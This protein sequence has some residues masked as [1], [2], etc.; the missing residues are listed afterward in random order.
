MKSKWL[1]SFIV[2]GVTYVILAIFIGEGLWR[3]NAFVYAFGG[4][5]AIIYYNM[6]FHSWY[7]QG[8]QLHNMNYP[9]GES[10]LMTDA[11]ASI[12][13]ILSKFR[14]ASFVQNNIVG[15]VHSF[16][17]L[18]LGLAAIFAQRA[19]RKKEV[20]VLLSIIGALLIV[21][22]SPQIF[23]LRAGHFGLAYPV[24]FTAGLYAW[25]SVQ[26][27]A[28]I[29]PVLLFGAVLLFFG[30][31]NIY[32]LIL[33]GGWVILIGIVEWY[34]T[35]SRSFLLLSATS[36]IVV[37]M[38]YGL[39]KGTEVEMDRLDIQWGYYFNR[40]TFEGLTYPFTSLIGTLGAKA[41]TNI[42]PVCNLGLANLICLL[43]V[44]FSV[45]RKRFFNRSS[46]FS[47]R[48]NAALLWSAFLM[49][50]YAS[51]SLKF[52]AEAIPAATMFKA[53]G[54][55]AWPLYYALSF[56]SIVLISDFLKKGSKKN[57]NKSK[58]KRNWS[59]T[60]LIGLLILLWAGECFVY[61]KHQVKFKQYE[62]HYG[63]IK[64]ESL[65]KE[66]D[67]IP[68]ALDDFQAIY[69]LPVMVAWNDKFRYPSPWNTEYYSTRISMVT[70]LP[71]LNAKLSRL[72][73][74]QASA[75]TQLASHPWIKKEMLHELDLSKPIML[76]LGKDHELTEGEQWLIDHAE[77]ILSA[78]AYA[79]YKLD[80]KSILKPS[81]YSCNTTE[82]SFYRDFDALHK[83]DPL[84][85]Q[86][87]LFIEKSKEKHVLLQQEV[88]SWPKE[89][90]E[91]SVWVHTDH[92]KYGMPWMEILQF[93][94]NGNQLD[95]AYFDIASSKDVLKNW[96]RA[97]VEMQ[98]SSKA[99]RIEVALD[100]LNQ[101]FKIDEF[102]IRALRDTICIKKE[103]IVNKISINNYI[104]IED[105]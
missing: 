98:L 95:R 49:W 1:E 21:F 104:Q 10:I 30:V 75:A 7:G 71:M 31:N 37:A 39:M 56:A 19:L 23:R 91:Y 99:S 105:Q 66:L 20:T 70:A 82:A 64:L 79:L 61:L 50:I 43:L 96:R 13:F 94:N 90:Y 85:G 67:S 84:F 47:F 76:V 36:F 4:D 27:K 100:R 24:V 45:F 9:L 22:L 52:L 68:H 41:K 83:E 53:S 97:G 26:K 65:K 63:P 69:S 42:E 78:K 25:A 77:Q 73:V 34:K 33:A 93:D 101:D 103:G 18:C 46:Q 60:G 86:G 8:L 74:T 28:K 2:L 32:L 44:V 59:K 48:A 35:K 38:V 62:N 54:R 6:I 80:L 88:S 15:I 29:Y 5:A 102:M 11:Q 3:P 57:I 40:S 17:Y 16:H 12:S 87:C 72:G 89:N 58:G 14:K 51:G 92:K 81:D 55:F